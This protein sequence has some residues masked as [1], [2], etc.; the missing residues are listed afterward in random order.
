MQHT[1]TAAAYDAR[2]LK[3][4]LPE[5]DSLKKAAER[6]SADPVSLTNIG[7]AVGQQVR[8]KRGDDPRF[9]AVYTVNQRNPDDP[10]RA[11]IVRAGLYQSAEWL[12]LGIERSRW[13]GIEVAAAKTGAVGSMMMAIN[14]IA[15]HPRDDIAWGF[16]AI[17]SHWFGLW[18]RR[19]LSGF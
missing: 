5:Q 14:T 9:V 8:I 18:A 19:S 2:I 10:S 11:D 6:C 12:T 16:S 1:S 13:R 7:R 4:R 17:Q 3:L 15:T